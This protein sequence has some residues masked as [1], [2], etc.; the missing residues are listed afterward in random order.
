MRRLAGLLLPVPFLAVALV[1]IGAAADPLD[2]P[3]VCPTSGPMVCF[4]DASETPQVTIPAGSADVTYLHITATV[5]NRGT[6]TA[7]HFTISD[8]PP[9]GVSVLGLTGVGGSGKAAA[10]TA[11]TGVCSYGSLAAGRSATFDA[12]LSISAAAAPTAAG[13]PN[14]NTLTLLVDEG[15]NDNPS[16]GGKVDT[17]TLS[18]SLDLVTRD[19]TSVYSY[20]RAGVATSLTTD[21]NGQPFAAATSDQSGNEVGTTEI[22]ANLSQSVPASVARS[23]AG[24][25]PGTC[26]M[27]DWMAVSLPDFP[28]ITPSGYLKT[29]VRVDAALVATVKGLSASNAVI[30]YQ[31]DLTTVPLALPRCT[32]AKSGT[33]T[34][35][36]CASAGKEKDGDITIVVYERHNGRI[37][38]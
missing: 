23:Q 15:T 8:S 36:G 1:P 11:S 30:W 13:V 32:F 20:V 18:R 27:T 12:V 29:T 16:N 5:L 9:A 7:T 17:T 4:I 24:A 2:Y 14:T 38:M 34:T 31:P 33:P 26:A 3:G 35:V 6:S 28:N 37:R 22:P 10:C 21:K 19:G 25:C